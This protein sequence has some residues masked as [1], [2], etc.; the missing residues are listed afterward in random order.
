MDDLELNALVFATAVTDDPA[1]L[2]QVA[3]LFGATG[4]QIRETPYAFVGSAGAVADQLR[5]A[6]E[7]WGF[8]YFILQGEVYEAMA[9]VVAELSGT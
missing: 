2:D 5:A 9:P 4:D 7:R 6:R 3:G 8:S 1:M